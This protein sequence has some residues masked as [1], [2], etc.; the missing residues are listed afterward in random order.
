M[1][2][3]LCVI[4]FLITGFQLNSQCNLI[5][6]YSPNPLPCSQTALLSVTSNTS[7]IVFGEDFNSGSPVGWQWTQTVTIANNTCN[8]PSLDGSNFMWMGSASQHPRTMTTTAVDLSCGGDIC[9]EMR[10]AIQG[11][12]APC[13][14]PDLT[15]EG[16]YLQ[17]SLN[18]STWVNIDYWPPLNAG[19]SSSPMTQW[20]Q[21]CRAIPTAAQTTSTYIRWHQASSSSS[22]YDHWGLDNIGV[23][24]TTCGNYQITWLHD[25]YSLPTG[26]YNGTN[27]NG[28]SPT[29]NT[30]YVVQ[31]TNGITTCYDTINVVVDQPVLTTN[32]VTICEGESTTLNV[33]SSITGGNYSW[34]N[35]SSANSINVSPTST[36][37]YNVDYLL[38]PCPTV[39]NNV[40]VT[41]NP[42][43]TVSINSATICEGESITLTA[44]PSQTGGTF[45]WS[46][47]STSSS[48]TVSPL[49]SSSYSVI[50]NLG[51][52]IPA[53]DTALVTV[54]AAPT[55]TLLNDSICEGET[56]VLTANPSQSGGAYSW[57]TGA[58]SQGISVNPLVTST[59]TVTYTL[60]GCT[61]ASAS[62]SVTVNPAPTISVLDDSICEGETIILSAIPSQSGGSFSWSNG[63]TTQDISVN[64]ITTTNY[65][66]TYTLG[67]CTPANATAVLTVNPAPIISVSND[68]ICEG[69]SALLVCTSNQTGGVFS[70]SNNWDQDSLF[71]NPI[72]TSYYS[73]TYTLGNCTVPIDSG[74][75]TVTPA[76]TVQIN[77]DSI[78]VGE[79]STLTAIPS[80]TGGTF[81]WSTNST[82]NNINVTPTTTSTYYVDYNLGGCNTAIDSAL[83]NVNPLPVVTVNDIV[84]CE[85]ATGTLSA[86]VDQ[87]GGTFLWSTGA[88]TQSINSNPLIP[89]NYT[90]TYTLGGCTPVDASGLI[91]I[92]LAPSVSVSDVTI[93]NGET[94][95]LNAILS[96]NDPSQSGG[97][98]LWST[99]A[100]TQDLNVSPSIS[101]VYIVSYNVG[102]CLPAID[103]ATITVNPL[104]DVSF[105]AS[106]LEGCSPLTTQL[107]ANYISSSAS[108][109]WELSDGQSLTGN[110]ISPTFSYPGN[111][112]VF[113]RV[114]SDLGCVDSLL[115][116]NYIYVEEDPQALFT[117]TPTV[118]K[119][120]S[121]QV[122]FFNQ[123]IGANAFVWNFGDG[124]QSTL[125]DPS[126][127]YDNTIGGHTVYLI[128][129]SPLNCT[130]TTSF[131]IPYEE[132]LVYYIPNSFTPDG[133]GFNQTFQP[134]FTSGF[135][136][137]EFSM[138][139]FNRWGEIVFESKNANIGWDG[140]YGINGEKVQE[141]VYSYFIMYKI[142]AIDERRIVTGHVS[143]IR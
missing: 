133:D 45:L 117:P 129:F 126:H 61:P 4:I 75:V 80:Q 36:T 24:A 19:S 83:V 41:V 84:I 23:S 142:P 137:N 132:G 58:S 97:T 116:P 143:L 111:Y 104:P 12:S 105:S 124:G 82:S 35:G 121:E 66:V 31:M 64:P 59:Y 53:L 90:V 29:S 25:N 85:G 65:S 114:I 122:T 115:V 33:S 81:L 47:G 22:I 141:G 20:A 42:A 135:D 101:G 32:D 54:N 51:G 9:F 37:T 91:D 74:L 17:Y 39:T 21:Y 7:S 94:A 110:P 1:K 119:D 102:G 103:S 72:V 46:N 60:A 108:Y 100:T 76:P 18:N 50:Y 96:L 118:F 123:T 27:P 28:V 2:K 136:P 73:V 120:L 16:V 130:D 139:I 30:S 99:A 56:S 52:C 127:W 3:L 6:T 78:C 49:L 34:S 128:A 8:V 93:C 57:S 67:G 95:Q 63:S 88:S 62:A 13:E 106:I 131:E 55:V 113:L 14:G 134:V 11:H 89:T 125:S 5:G 44:T 79:S 15:N 109:L 43:P 70:W 38:S 112:D 40:T 71:V 92:H 26:T 69:E 48:I 98:F 138:K 140:S 87:S 86:I 68:S 10:Y 77:N 107:N